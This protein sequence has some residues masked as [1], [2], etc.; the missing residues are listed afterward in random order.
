[1][2]KLK[3]QRGVCYKDIYEENSELP[4]E[5]KNKIIVG[6]SEEVLKRFPN[7]CIDLIL[8]S[9]PY[10]YGREYDKHNDSVQW[11]TYFKKLFSILD[12][13]IRVLKY[14]GRIV[15]NVRPAFTDNMPTHHIISNFLLQRKLIWKGEILWDKNDYCKYTAWGSWCSPSNPYLQ[16]GWEYLEIFCKGSLKHLGNNP[17]IT[18]DEF[19]TW[20]KAKWEIAPER[21][22]IN[23]YKHPAVFPEELAY[24]VIK[25]FSFKGDVVL[26]P[27][28]GSGTTTAVAK[29]LGRIFVGIDISEEYCFVARSRL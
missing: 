21:D 10:N 11:D 1:M 17:D 7:N 16:Y 6:D 28:N 22:M 18:P 19:K 23:K 13:C 29:K 3:K 26:D 8:T 14:G 20:I 15:I 24:R 25:L 9:P 5:L 4:D 27:F 2:K 12:E